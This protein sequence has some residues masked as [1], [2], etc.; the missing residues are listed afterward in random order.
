MKSLLIV[1]ILLL[2]GCA[3][4]SIHGGD[5]AQ[6][7]LRN[8]WSANYELCE[9]LTVATLA[10]EKIREEWIN[11][12]TGRSVDC[13]RY[14]ATTRTAVNQDLPFIRW[15]TKLTAPKMNST[16][17]VPRQLIHAR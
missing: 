9:R 7:Q 11:E 1:P 12:I 14:V 10:P 15:S 8:Q 16:I 13:N 5:S 2:A 17:P 6:R 4:Y 3:S